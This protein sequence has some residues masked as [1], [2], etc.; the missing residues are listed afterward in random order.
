MLVALTVALASAAA[1][2]PDVSAQAA[3]QR[4]VFAYYFGWYSSD[5]WNSSQLLDRPAAPYNSADG[6]VIGRQI[7]QAKSAGIDAFVMSWFGPKNGNLTV[8]VFNALLDQSAAKGFHAAA[9]VD[10]GEAGYN[11][12]VGEVTNSI[13]SLVSDRVNHP[14]YLRYQGKPLIY[15]W[16]EHRFSGADWASIRKQ[17]DPDHHTLWVT[18]G[19]DTSLIPTFDSLYLFNTSWSSNPLS[20]ANTW[21]R[22][23]LGAGGVFYGPT[24]TPGWNEALLGRSVKTATEDR[25][26]GHFLAN[27]FSGAAAS[28]ADVILIVSWNEF[29]EGSYIEPSQKYGTVSLDTLRPLIAAWK[30]GAPVSAAAS[31]GS[32]APA[33]PTGKTLTIRTDALRVRSGAGANFPQIGT[34]ALGAVYP[35][36]DQKGNWYGILLNGQKGYVSGDFVSVNG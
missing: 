36:I 7:D 31:G 18:E 21:A 24:V 22:R 12:T 23:T 16:N 32:A 28:G 3:G 27:S 25:A 11:A 13:R 14:G 26:N 10:M 2:R 29:F 35:V 30:S 17:T 20:T 33:S 34:A 8:G 9:S 1:F 5:S 15:F 6:G 4:Q 19:A